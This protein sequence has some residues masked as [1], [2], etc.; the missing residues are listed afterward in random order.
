[1]IFSVVTEL[2]M[3]VHKERPELAYV[4]FLEIRILERQQWRTKSYFR[5]WS[6]AGPDFTEIVAVQLTDSL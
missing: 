5:S 4:G 2:M 6:H 3:V 1:L